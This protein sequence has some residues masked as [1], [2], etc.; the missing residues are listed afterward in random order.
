MDMGLEI[1]YG[2]GA[3]I[4]LTALIFAVLQHHFRNKRAVQ[5]GDEIV[6]KRYER[7]ET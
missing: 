3:L 4:L 2:I 7:N 5:R 1:I 6:R